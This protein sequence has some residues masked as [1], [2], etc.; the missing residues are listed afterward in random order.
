M[1][2]QRIGAD[3]RPPF[4]RRRL[5][6]I[7]FATGM[8]VLALGMALSALILVE[9]RAARQRQAQIQ[10]AAALA[11]QTGDVDTLAQTLERVLG[12]PP[13][14]AAALSVSLKEAA[15]RARAASSP[16]VS[17]SQGAAP[18]AKG[19]GPDE[20]AA[21]GDNVDVVIRDASGKVKDRWSSK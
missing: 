7:V 11:A 14:Q 8:V 3:G 4:I 16:N 1:V 9:W 17:Q 20:K 6:H 2:E 21:L 13:E 10:A 15:E 19:G 12:L 18:A 5:H